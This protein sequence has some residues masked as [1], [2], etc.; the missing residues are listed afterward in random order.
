[1]VNIDSHALLDRIERCGT[2]RQGAQWVLNA[3]DPFHDKDMPLAPFP[4][5]E[6]GRSV[7]QSIKKNM[8]ITAPSSVSAGET[9][10]CHVVL[11]PVVRKG[12]YQC[13]EQRYLNTDASYG[14][15]TAM[16][17]ELR[18]PTTERTVSIPE[19]IVLASSVPSQQATFNNSG[20]GSGGNREE[21]NGITIDEHLPSSSSEGAFRL[22]GVGFEVHNVTP[23]LNKSGAV[24]V[25]E[26]ASDDS[27]EC[28]AMKDAAGSLK[29]YS[30]STRLIK[31]PPI[32]EGNAKLLGG[33]TWSAAE[34]CY[35]P[36]R[37]E[38]E[39][40]KPVRIASGFNGIMTGEYDEDPTKQACLVPADAQA[41]VD[42]TADQGPPAGARLATSVKGAYFTGLSYETVLNVNLACFMEQFPASNSSLITLAN[43]RP[44]ADPQALECYSRIVAEMHP[45]VMVKHNDAGDFFRGLVKTAHS[46]LGKAT[47]ALNTLSRAFPNPYLAGVAKA[48]A[49]GHAISGDVVKATRRNKAKKKKRN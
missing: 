32:N 47:P 23:E 25:Y 29:G 36:G 12:V 39:N 3:L 46:V 19:G 45:G 43:P 40:S 13:Y 26:Q 17:N 8:T 33:L 31:G 37:I 41:M 20:T 22:L 18:H 11:L 5:A 49:A 6:A 1:M 34:G 9:W 27:T 42:I 38:I 21:F 4:D 14:S 10:D 24:T 30:Q 28:F 35:F 2:T 7:V 48:A 44:G 15:D 16:K